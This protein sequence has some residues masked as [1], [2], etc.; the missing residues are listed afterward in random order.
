M[1]NKP[2]RFTCPPNY[3]SPTLQLEQHSNR[4]ANYFLGRGFRKGD[5]V[6]LF[7]EN[8]TEYVATW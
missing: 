4:I 6:A 8:R 2:G 1:S 5:V 3:N 7:M